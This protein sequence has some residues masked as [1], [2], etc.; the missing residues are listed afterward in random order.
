MLKAYRVQRLALRAW[1]LEASALMQKERK[2]MPVALS[3][4]AQLGRRLDN[5][6]TLRCR[7]TVGLVEGA[8]PRKCSIF[9]IVMDLQPS[10]WI[11]E[12]AVVDC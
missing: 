12:V 6:E 8:V 9:M 5:F 10:P 1:D 4:W 3:T 7:Q 11:V 2:L